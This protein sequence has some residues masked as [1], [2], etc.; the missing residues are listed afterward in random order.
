MKTHI[1][2]AGARPAAFHASFLANCGIGGIRVALA[3][4]GAAHAAGQGD[5]AGEAEFKA[6][7]ANLKTI[8]DEV[9]RLAEGALGEAKKAGALSDETKAAVDKGLSDFNIKIREFDTR[10]ADAE[11][12]AARRGGPGAPMEQK[13][14]GQ[15]VIENEEVKATILGGSQRGK[16]AMTIETKAITTAPATFG[17][18]NSISN[19][20]VPAE[21]L[22]GVVGLP[23]RPL[24]VRDLLAQGQTA[25]NAIE[26]AVQTARTN[27]AAPVPETQPKPYSDY[28]WNLKSF[29]VRTIAHLVKASRQIL[30]DA[31]GLRSTIDAEMRYGIQLTE[32]NQLLVGDGTGANILGLVPQAST[33]TGAFQVTGE[34]AIDRLRLAALQ[35]VLAFLPMDGYVLNPTDWARIE[36]IKDGMGRYLIGDPQGRIVP[37]LWNLPVSPSFAM[38]VGT[39]LTGAFKTAAQIFDRMA[40][41]VLISTENADDFEK[42]MITIRAEERLALVVKRPNAFITGTLPA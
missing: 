37:Q 40:I 30:D 19:S 38:P 6:A 33:Y 31:P 28:T 14:L 25:S 2:L 27:A 10:L 13:S 32:E 7:A 26:F 18:T 29:P 35:G 4:E 24:T 12:K 42:N 21:R 34:T 1:L 5:G 20:L 16:V 8:G 39:F 36:T 9:R 22:A 41:E 3:P 23:Q 11:Q 15:L 17:N